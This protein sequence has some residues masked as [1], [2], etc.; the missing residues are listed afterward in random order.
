MAR[1]LKK[2]PY[3]DPKLLKKVRKAKAE[4]SRKPIRTWSRRSTITPEMV[5]LTF[6]V[7]NGKGFDLV[8]ASE[9]MVGE[10]LGQFAATRKFK[11]HS[12]KGKISKATG[13][14]GSGPV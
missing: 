3:T 8:F 12:K 11:G 5:N 13:T 14:S 2:G 10:K 1:S 9:S 6:E 4:G 7:H